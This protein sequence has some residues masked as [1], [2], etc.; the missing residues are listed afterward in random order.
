MKITIQEL[1]ELCLPILIKRGL[2]PEDAETIFAE[3]LDGELRGREC[4]GISAFTTFG[5]KVV[6]PD[7]EEEVL[8]DESGLLYI[9][10]NGNLGQL[11]C[12]KFVP[13]LIEK[14]KKSNLAMMGIVNMSSYLMPGTYA[15]MIAEKD[16]VC[17][18][19][20]YGGAP[21]LVPTGANEG[22]L[23]INPIAIGIPGKEFPL[24]SDYSPAVIA[25]GKV[26]LA[27]KLG[28]N[29]PAGIA[30]DENGKETIKA[31]EVV[32]LLPFGGYK[33]YALALT[34]EILSRTMLNVEEKGKRGFFF[35]TIN[36]A[37]FQDINEFKENVSKLISEIKTARK[38]EGVKEIFVPGE[39]SEKLK[40]ENLKK[41]YLEIDDKIINEIKEMI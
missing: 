31:E 36:P 2:S 27:K 33:G 35:M 28:K 19:F 14:A 6:N 29:I 13:Q 23:G 15:R 10:G 26:R 18:I 20:N 25:M 17:F 8:K 24:V 30:L 11:V 34:G 3:Y 40:Q 16:L 22:V 5:N 9:N 21:R 7:I 37:A 41:G 4:H 39:R 12:N 32:S 38:A 1:K